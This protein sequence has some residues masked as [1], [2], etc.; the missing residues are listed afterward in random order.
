MLPAGRERLAGQQGSGRVE[1]SLWRCSADTSPAGVGFHAAQA[2][3][4]CSCCVCCKG[5]EH[6]KNSMSHGQLALQLRVLQWQSSGL[7]SCL[8]AQREASVGVM[9]TQPLSSRDRSTMATPSLDCAQM[10]IGQLE[11]VDP[12]QCSIKRDDHDAL[13]RTAHQGGCACRA[14]L[15]C[16]TSR[17]SSAR[18]PGVSGSSA[19][20]YSFSVR[21]IV[22]RDC[23]RPGRR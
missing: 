11:S 20:L 17:L 9:S 22:I 19:S 8:A 7:S 23:R 6:H 3:K 5:R 16:A 18:M 15:A 13:L 12:V 2:M 1:G 4:A 10:H 21:A 14:E